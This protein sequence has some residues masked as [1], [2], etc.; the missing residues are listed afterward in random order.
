MKE[1]FQAYVIR[2]HDQ[3]GVTASI[4]Q[5][6]KEDLPN[7][8]VTVKVH[9]SSVNY[10]DGLATVEK[11]GV[12]RQYPMV[13]G[14]DLVGTV[15]ES[16]SGRFAP[17]DRVISTG[18]EPGVS[19]YGG[20]SEYAR[21]QSEWL[22]P[23]PQGLSEQEAMAIGTAGFTAALSVDALIH[24]GITPEMG[25]ILVTGAT[26]GVGSMAIAILAKL[27]Y[28]VTAS[29]GK[30]QQEE[31]L[32]RSL[33]AAE[34]ISREEADAPIK[35]AMGKQQWAA[36]VDPTAGQ[37][38]AERLKQVQYGGAVAVSGLTGGSG[39]ES[40]VF[41]FILRGIQLI[42]I[43]SVY[44][45]MA[46]RERIWTKLGGDWKPDRAL[47][48]GVQEI[49]LEQLPHTLENILKGGAVGRTVVRICS[50]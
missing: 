41:P 21:L 27:G 38:L 32:L 18:F 9:Y 22:V 16:V 33:G 40:T 25:K 20:Y 10:K 29:T 14:I 35:G 12:V 50:E 39:F 44:C 46:R 43:D 45:P 11:G 2:K 3:Q 19:H 23:L 30:K 37:A 6:K 13:P 8:D 4:E 28:A 42:G 31:A 1:Q 24:A 48:L 49:T 15:E 7:G 36:V 26:G 5:L 34:V 47:A 17:G